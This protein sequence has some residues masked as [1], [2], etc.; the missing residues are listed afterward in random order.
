MRVDERVFPAPC[1]KAPGERRPPTQA[2]GGA[3]V[4]GP[5]PRLLASS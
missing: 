2:L 3:S 4:S 5:A 1:L